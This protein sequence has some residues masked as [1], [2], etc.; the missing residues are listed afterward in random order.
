[1]SYFITTGN[2]KKSTKKYIKQN[3]SESRIN[4]IQMGAGKT[5]NVTIEISKKFLTQVWE[6]VKTT[7]IV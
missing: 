6:T 3:I 2:V 5:K 7:N 4:D 1:M